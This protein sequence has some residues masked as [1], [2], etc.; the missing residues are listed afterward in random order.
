LTMEE[1]MIKYLE[2][3][4][5]EE[6]IVGKI[7]SIYNFYETIFGK[8]IETIFVSEYVEASGDRIFENLWFFADNYVGEAKDFVSQD[9]FDFV[10][11]DKLLGVAIK[12]SD[13]DGIGATEKSRL[14]VEFNFT[15]FASGN[16]K[17]SKNNCDYLMKI[18]HEI[19]LPKMNLGSKHRI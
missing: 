10:K 18:V 2:A 14:N 16:L 8:K 9:N 11:L 1:P 3:I 5:I 13:Y 4:R 15:E 7:R 12:K 17:A 6:P 19:L